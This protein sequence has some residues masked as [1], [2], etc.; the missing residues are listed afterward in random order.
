MWF[1][2]GEQGVQCSGGGDL[3]LGAGMCDD[4]H[5]YQVQTEHTGINQSQSAT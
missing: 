1:T 5:V 4:L 2:L 3:L